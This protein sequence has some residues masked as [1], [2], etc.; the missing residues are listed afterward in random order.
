MN[1]KELIDFAI[2]QFRIIAER[3]RQI[4]LGNVSHNAKYLEG[5]AKRCYEY[6]ENHKNDELCQKEK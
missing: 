2:Y 5:H 4:T 6:L 1:D 3:A